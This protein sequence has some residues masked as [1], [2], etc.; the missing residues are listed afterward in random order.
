MTLSR[1][2]LALSERR[3]RSLYE[4]VRD[5][6]DQ[7]VIHRFLVD[8]YRQFKEAGQEYPFV[9]KA[10]LKPGTRSQNLPEADMV[11]HHHGLVIY[12]ENNLSSE[13]KKYLRFKR[14]NRL[15]KKNLA[16]H[17]LVDEK[18]A[19]EFSLP[20][21]YVESPQ[22]EQTMNELLQEDYS[23]LLQADSRVRDPA[24]YCLTHYRVKIEWPTEEAAEALAREFGYIDQHLYEHGETT[25][26]QLVAKLYEYYGFH[27]DTV[28]GRR[29][30]A[31]LAAA[32]LRHATENAFTVYVGSSEARTLT[33]ITDDCVSK[34]ILL[35]RDLLQLK[36]IQDRYPDFSE[37][38]L[39]DDH[40]CVYRVRYA[41]TKAAQAEGSQAFSSSVRWITHVGEHLIPLKEFPEQRPLPYRILYDPKDSFADTG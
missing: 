14:S 10:A 1:E 18:F 33:R 29:S 11:L 34:F 2:D 9:D 13:H 32:F 4:V 40:V 12:V 27:H 24:R 21:T 7:I 38:F 8:S 19:S 41:P 26:E 20:T 25:A 6:L 3:R 28:G 17:R 22:F 23:L 37:R 36:Q 5:R 30:A 39:I 16:A 31:I 35:S 15:T